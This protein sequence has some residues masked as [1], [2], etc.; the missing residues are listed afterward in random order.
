MIFFF[1]ILDGSRDENHRLVLTL[2]SLSF[3]LNV[4]PVAG[5]FRFVSVYENKKDRIKIRGKRN[6]EGEWKS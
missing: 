2:L 6:E 1:N 3:H 4:T 5:K